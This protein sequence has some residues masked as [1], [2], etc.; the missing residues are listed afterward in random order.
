MTQPWMSCGDIE[1]PLHATK[2]AETF[3]LDGRGL[4]GARAPDKGAQA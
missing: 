2:G 3:W 1:A 4:R